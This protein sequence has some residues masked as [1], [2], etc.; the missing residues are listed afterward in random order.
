M[1]R[2]PF[3]SA[4]VTGASSGI[5]ESMAVLL[6]QAGVAC[7]LVARR[8]DRLTEIADRY[9]NFE[10]LEA[11]LTTD[12]GCARVVARITDS[13]HPIDL[14]V[15]NAGF[16]SSGLFHEIESARLDD[17]IALNIRALT[18][19]SRAAIE[20]MVERKRGWLLNVSSVASFQPAPKLAV[21]AATKA[22]VTNLTESLHEEVRGTGVKVTA[23]CPGL[24]RTEFQS[25]SNTS[26]YQTQFPEFLWCTS[27]EVARVGLEDVVKGKALSVPG[28]LYKGLVGASSVLPG[29]LKRLAARLSLK[30][31]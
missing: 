20:V 1:T 17:E 14:V 6:G 3:R 8:G 16:G 23:L 10:V 9:S 12:E 18:R 22:Y 25:V 11:D 15:N 29:P 5:G 13:Q 28:A 19:L 30:A 7:V 26:D 2:Y 24:T 27:E 21:Y 31:R 4:L